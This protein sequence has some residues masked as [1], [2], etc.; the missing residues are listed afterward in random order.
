[1]SEHR[2]GL[3]SRPSAVDDRA[4]V[5]LAVLAALPAFFA[6]N[7]FFAVATWHGTNLNEVAPLEI[8]THPTGSDPGGAILE[9]VA[10]LDDVSGTR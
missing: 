5:F 4:A 2:T 10:L 3:G 1:V 8:A 9:A 6:A 7:P